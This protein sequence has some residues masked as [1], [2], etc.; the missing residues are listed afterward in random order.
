MPGRAS[1]RL[2]QKAMSRKPESRPASVLELV[3]ELQAVETELACPADAIEV[4]MD[5]WALATVSDLEERTRIRPVAGA[6]IAC[7]ATETATLGRRV[8][9][10]GDRHAAARAEPCGPAPRAA[11]SCAG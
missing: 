6:A 2:L 11:P 4:A 5:D 1:E 8:R 10:R 3:R 7:Q 9:L